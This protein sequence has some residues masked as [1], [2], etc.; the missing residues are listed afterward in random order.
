M[1]QPMMVYDG[2]CAFCRRMISRWRRTTGLRV[3]YRSYQKVAAQFPEVS[4]TQFENA[5]FL[6]EPQGEFYSGADAVVRCLAYAPQ[7]RWVFSLYSRLLMLRLIC[8]LGYFFV[9]RNR[10]LASR[11]LQWLRVI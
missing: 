9:A 2:Q 7:Y 10:R 4:L 8:R 5:V 3:R 11:I 1:N 6:F